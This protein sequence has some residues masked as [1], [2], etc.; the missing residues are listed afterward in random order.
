MTCSATGPS[1]RAGRKLRP[2]TTTTVQNRSP[3]K[4]AEPEGIEPALKG[5][6]RC[7]TKDPARARA[8]VAEAKRPSNMATAVVMFQKGELT[9]RA[10]MAWPLL[11]A[12]EA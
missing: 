7:P 4:R 6:R 10:P 12:H 8:R 11:A 5:F 9:D 1:T 2:V 3:P